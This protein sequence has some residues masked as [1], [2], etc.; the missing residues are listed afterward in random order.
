[1]TTLEQIE[2]LRQELVRKIVE[3]TSLPIT[4]FEVSI[5][6]H[7]Q[8]ANSPLITEA[9]KLDWY[10]DEHEGSSWY[11]SEKPSGG[12]TVVFLKEDEE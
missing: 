10:P 6:F 5:N 11:T 4:D 7:D 9:K 12:A 8:G 1:M 2:Q 3:L